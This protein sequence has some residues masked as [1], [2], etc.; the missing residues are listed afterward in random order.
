M[1]FIGP[2]LGFFALMKVDHCLVVTVDEGNIFP[3]AVISSPYLEEPWTIMETKKPLASLTVSRSVCVG[4]YVVRSSGMFNKNGVEAYV[5]TLSL[6]N[7]PSKLV[8]IGTKTDSDITVAAE[9][10]K[11]LFRILR[12]GE[13][14]LLTTTDF[15]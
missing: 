3:V 15:E 12:I 13:Q 2:V 1:F 4:D 8:A 14:V 11:H 6:V 7:K 5:F 10:A 9:T